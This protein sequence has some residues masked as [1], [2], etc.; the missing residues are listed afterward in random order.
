[1][2]MMT[3]VVLVLVVHGSDSDAL[4]VVDRGARCV[5]SRARGEGLA[6]AGAE[7]V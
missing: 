4:S 2:M 7:G 1:M 3:M 6:G 5:S